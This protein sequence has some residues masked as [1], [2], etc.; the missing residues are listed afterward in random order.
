[1]KKKIWIIDDCSSILDSLRMLLE[2]YQYEVE[3][4][5]N[6]D[7]VLEDGKMPPDIFLIDYHVPHMDICALLKSLKNNPRLLS[8]PVVLVSGDP[9]IQNISERLGVNDFITKPFD[10]EILL[11]KIQVLTHLE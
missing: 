7:F 3:V 8:I 11:T 2:L 1:M 6:G 10:I 5:Q 4:S 9:N